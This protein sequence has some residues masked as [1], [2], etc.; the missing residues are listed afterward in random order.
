MEIIKP[1]GP[2]TVEEFIDSLRFFK[3][4]TPVYFQT[5][6]G[7]ITDLMYLAVPPNRKHSD[8]I[9][10]IVDH[11]DEMVQISQKQWHEDRKLRHETET[12]V[13]VGFNNKPAFCKI[14][15]T[16]ST[17]NAFQGKGVFKR[18]AARKGPSHRPLQ[19]GVPFVEF[20]GKAFINK[21]TTQDVL[22]L[23]L[24]HL[25]RVMEEA[26]IVPV[27]IKGRKTGTSRFIP[28][29]AFFS[30]LLSHRCED[31][32]TIPELP[33]GIKMRMPLAGLL[34]GTVKESK[35]WKD[36]YFG[37]STKTVNAL[38]VGKMKGTKWGRSNPIRTLGELAK[39]DYA[40][41][42]RYKNL[43]RQGVSQITKTLNA[44][45]MNDVLLS[46]R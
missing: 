25:N 37:L 7:V 34:N 39:C 35:T 28:E 3:P 11:N 17:S 38:T 21:G 41:L 40:Q 43:G 32:S 44:C 10:F 29:E 19:V 8:G 22:D 12:P 36:K 18:N 46:T 26:S 42:V 31:R 45:N 30:L 16:L 15:E 2:K 6:W 24:Y 20:D 27:K 23:S 14:P 13:D 9:T 5:N 1:Y 33:L 4:E